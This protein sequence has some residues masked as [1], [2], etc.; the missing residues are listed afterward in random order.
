MFVFVR[1]TTTSTIISVPWSEV[2]RNRSC[3]MTFTAAVLEGVGA[4]LSFADFRVFNDVELG[5]G[6]SV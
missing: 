4:P 3:C 6:L 1:P 5:I 2:L